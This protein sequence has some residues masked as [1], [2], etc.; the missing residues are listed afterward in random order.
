MTKIDFDEPSTGT[1]DNANETALTIKVSGTNSIGLRCESTSDQSRHAIS[2]RTKVS[3][4]IVGSSERSMGINGRGGSIG[5]FG[6]TTTN[7]VGVWGFSRGVG[8]PLSPCAGVFGHNMGGGIGIYGRGTT[9]GR[10]EGDVEVTGDIKLL[11][12]QN[13]DFAEDFDILEENVEPGTVMILSENYSLQTSYQEYDK[14]VAG[15]ISGAGGYS[16]AIIL[17]KEQ[18]SDS[19]KNRRRLP[20][21]LVGKVYCKVDARHSPI[22]TGDLL[23][24]SSTKGHAMR[25]QDPTKAF[26]AVIG[27]A[28]GSIKHGMGM[29]PVLVT[30]Q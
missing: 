20:I 30:L 5:V 4:A 23:T 3:T 13:A 28:L 11:N 16:P 12:P 17:G 8:T 25:A 7:S 2:A 9:A 15:I 14:K 29:I 10:F 27:K 24:T 21:A 1:L 18:K 26:G 6:E 22:E 19:Q